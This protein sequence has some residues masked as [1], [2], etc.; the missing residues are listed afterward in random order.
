MAT[1]VVTQAQIDPSHADSGIQLRTNRQTNSTAAA[2]PEP[3]D[4]VLQASL[5]AD[6]TVPDG[7]YGWVVIVA[8]AVVSFWFT[9]VNYSWGVMQAALVDKGLSSASKLSFVG[10]IPPTLIAAMAIVNS[11]IVRTIGTRWSA[12]SGVSLLVVAQIASS[13]SANSVIG[14]YMTAGL[15]LGLGMSLCFAT[16]SVIPAQYFKNRRGLANGIVF[17]GGGLGGATVT[18]IEGILIQR[19][20]VPWTYRIMGLATLVTGL[21]AAWVITERTKIR[22][23]GFVEWRLFKD[24]R[25][26]LMFVA[27]ALATFPLLVPAFF[28][29]LYSQSLG[30]SPSTGAGLLAGFNFSS[31]LGRI[32]SGFLSDKIGG[33]NTLLL[34]LIV[35]SLAM[36]ALWPASTSLAPLA[37]FAILSG[38]TNGGFFATIPTVVGNVFG[39]ARV[40]IAL[41]MIVT[42]WGAGYLMVS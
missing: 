25:F 6:S 41:S 2:T 37:I 32:L 21:P 29:P 8:C 38:S 31:A 18:I 14:L 16:C 4:D 11:R 28:L 26:T 40:S 17:A 35:A 42:G 20:G 1:V 22:S 24:A 19:V 36:L 15:I 30:L 5:L 3:V 13:F 23:S 39:S 7:G 27:S 33:T 12:V 9:G 10:S 34:G